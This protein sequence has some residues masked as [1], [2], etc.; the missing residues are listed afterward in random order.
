MSRK[1]NGRYIRGSQTSWP[2]F[3]P[4]SDSFFSKIENTKNRGKGY[5]E[6]PFLK[7][8]SHCGFWPLS[9]ALMVGINEDILYPRF[10]ISSS[11]RISRIKGGIY[12]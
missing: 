2:F 4:D 6:S 7:S 5:V 8:G 3:G 1:V 10:Q 11:G 12:F 9:A